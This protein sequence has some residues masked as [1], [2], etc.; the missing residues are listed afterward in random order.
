MKRMMTFQ[1]PF[2]QRLTVRLSI[3]LI[4]L[5][6]CFVAAS[7]WITWHVEKK[8]IEN[9]L[10]DDMEETLLVA[11]SALAYSV[12]SY[13]KESVTQL[14]K[15]LAES[16][17]SILTRIT[18]KD[19]SGEVLFAQSNPSIDSTDEHVYS[20]NLKLK[21]EVVG[22]VS[23][24]FSANNRM[25]ELREFA[26]LL[27]GLSLIVISGLSLIVF[28]TSH[29]LVAAPLSELIGYIKS[30]EGDPLLYPKD[31]GMTGELHLLSQS[32]YS[33]MQAIH[34]RDQHVQAFNQ[35]KLASLGEMAAGIAHEINNPLTV[36]DA[37]AHTLRGLIHRQG[38]PEMMYQQIDRIQAMVTRTSKIIKGLRAFAC[39]GSKDPMGTFSLQHTVS[40]TLTL[41]QSMLTTRQVQLTLDFPFDYTIHGQQ[42]QISHAIFNLL[43]NAI[44]AV[45]NEKSPLI[46]IAI[47]GTLDR[48]ELNIYD[49]GPGVPEKI[50]DKIFQPFFTTKSVDQGTGLGLSVTHGIAKQHQGS[51]GY[52][53]IEGN[54]VFSLGLPGKQTVKQLLKAA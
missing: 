17:K 12:W 42:V 14:A 48:C 47:T 54:T 24:A 37:K 53:R 23:V 50:K 20:A 16:Q 22:E 36:I 27:I 46:H 52:R 4:A 25:N 18:V 9:G 8:N 39:D 45:Q 7:L 2:F 28:F 3:V 49:N 38:D 43:Q 11:Q 35:A 26:W 5:L 10:R 33:A 32:F 1:V 15:L 31:D 6:S 19:S 34:A 21:D 41:C 44:D 30:A 40:D 13:D 29:R 51:L